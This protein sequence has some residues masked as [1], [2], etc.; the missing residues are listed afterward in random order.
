MTVGF[1]SYLFGT[2]H[3]I[4]YFI[5]ILYVPFSFFEKLIASSPIILTSYYW[6]REDLIAVVL[7]W[8][9]IYRVLVFCRNQV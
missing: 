9:I 1:F 7:L 8:V 6:N 2:V 5:S 4:Y 3:I